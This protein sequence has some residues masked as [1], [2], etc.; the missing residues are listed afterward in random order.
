MRRSVARGLVAA[1]LFVAACPATADEPPD[2]V[3][4]P[5][6]IVDA[7][8]RVEPEVV[9]AVAQGLDVPVIEGDA[10]RKLLGLVG[11]V[12]TRDR[13]AI[14]ADYAAATGAFFTG[15]HAEARDQL[16]A[17]LAEIEADP[18]ALAVEPALRPTGFGARLHLA[19][20][21]HGEADERTVKLQIAEAV[22]RYPE[23]EARSVDYPPWLRKMLSATKSQVPEPDGVVILEAPAECGLEVDGRA[24]MAD[25][26]TAPGITRGVHA[27]RARCDDRLSPIGSLPIDDE[28][29]SFRPLLLGHSRVVVDR[30]GMALEVGPTVELDA[31]VADVARVAR[32]AGRPRAVA[33]IG[34][35]A[36]FELVLVDAAGGNVIRKVWWDAHDFDQV[37]AKADELAASSAGEQAGDVPA[38]SDKPW[39]RNGLAWVATG[40]GLAIAGT[41]FALGRIHGTPSAEEPAA[42]ALMAAGAG[43]AGTGIVLFLVPASASGD[44]DDRV[45][46]LGITGTIAF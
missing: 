39:F 13:A 21:A 41:G 3:R 17:L 15:R 1:T 18:V 26:K 6:V 42:W 9:S 32:A 16:K 44:Q 40:I 23:L 7:G 35:I 4:L 45:S 2:A 11:P 28:P 8:R 27:L 5:I 34:R 46:T 43:V 10:L 29:V 19:M 30:Y 33:V 31:V 12:T 24:V 25:G 36:R 37:R 20:I 22:A 38:V 14:E